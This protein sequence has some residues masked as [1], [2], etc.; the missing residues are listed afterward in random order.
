MSD[1]TRQRAADA[2]AAADAAE[3]TIPTDAGGTEDEENIPQ[4]PGAADAAS[5]AFSEDAELLTRPAE[6]DNPFAVASE[7]GQGDRRSDAEPDQ[8]YVDPASPDSARRRREG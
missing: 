4:E 3:A 6:L 7:D 2:S 8:L 1:P 5:A